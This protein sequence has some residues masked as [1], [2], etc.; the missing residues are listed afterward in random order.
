MARARG[1]EM[2]RRGRGGNGK[3]E[4]GHGRWHGGSGF[5][6]TKTRGEA[7]EGRRKEE[8]DGDEEEEEALR[9][10]LRRRS[11]SAALKGPL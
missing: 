7:D 8:E 1:D 4:P 11:R 9:E 3:S 5:E 2:K 6:Q 10:P